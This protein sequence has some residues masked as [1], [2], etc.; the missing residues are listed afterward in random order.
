MSKNIFFP[1][2]KVIVEFLDI[3][4]AITQSYFIIF[5]SFVLRII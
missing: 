5:G 1:K 4:S 2:K 3:Y